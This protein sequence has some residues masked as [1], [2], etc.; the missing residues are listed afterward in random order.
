MAVNI[1]SATTSV[2]GA[3]M[4]AMSADLGRAMAGVCPASEEEDELGS[5]V[6]LIP[7]VLVEME[8]PV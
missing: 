7:D 8:I 3:N 5:P 4:M 1:R 2:T 6:D